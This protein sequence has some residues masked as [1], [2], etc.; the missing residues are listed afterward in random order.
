MLTEFVFFFGWAH[1]NVR[2]FRFSK[3]KNKKENQIFGSVQ[4]FLFAERCVLFLFFIWHLVKSILQDNP[5]T[6]QTAN[7]TFCN[8][9]FYYSFQV[10]VPKYMRSVFFYRLF[11]IWCRK[12][13]NDSQFSMQN[14]IFMH[15][16]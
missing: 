16:K 10:Q 15:V 1:F 8:L 13:R 6:A 9:N 5:E 11:S 7:K 4:L 2:Q 14:D 3:K 12:C